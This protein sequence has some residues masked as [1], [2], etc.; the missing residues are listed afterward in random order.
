MH[1]TK[2]SQQVHNGRQAFAE[3][4]SLLVLGWLLAFLASCL[5]ADT[6]GVNPVRWWRGES[7]AN[8]LFR[9][10]RVESERSEA[11]SHDD[12]QRLDEWRAHVYYSFDL[13]FILYRLR[14]DTTPD[15]RSEVSSA[16]RDPES[17]A[18][19]AVEPKYFYRAFWKPDQLDAL[20]HLAG[21]PDK[22]GQGLGYAQVWH[23]S[24]SQ[25][26]PYCVAN[27]FICG[28]LCSF[29]GLP[30]PPFAITAM[31]T[32]QK[33]LFSSLDFNFNR[34][35]LPP[36]IPSICVE[37]L[38]KLCAG[39]L[40]FDILIANEDRHDQNLHVDDQANPKFMHVYDHD[41]A[42]FGG[43]VTKGS[44]RLADLKN[45]L[46][47]TGGTT[48][49]GNRHIFLDEVKDSALLDPWIRR[50]T[51]VP[52]WLIDDTVE[53]AADGLGISAAEAL[54]AADFLK[55]RKGRIGTLIDANRSE[56]SAITDW[57]DEERLF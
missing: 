9:A 44:K 35:K 40:T 32:E 52:D 13:S 46:G 42:L 48:T 11:I 41:Q 19:V 30:I 21:G 16:A 22:Y 5:L 3:L 50:I 45:R 26:S 55:Y 1:L 49:G 37:K 23:K 36:V 57:P 15:S 17:E 8:S 14:F 27:E 51:L 33:V 20:K 4:P 12:L 7:P 18:L 34:A 47:I 25:A 53:Q 31:P 24:D 54:D 39:V 10:E 28:R 6:V 43:S 56:F 2:R 38:P 29:L